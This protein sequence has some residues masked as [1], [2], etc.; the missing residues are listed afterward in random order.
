MVEREIKDMELRHQNEKANLSIEIRRLNELLTIKQKDNDELKNELEKGKENWIQARE[1]VVHAKGKGAIQ[2]YW[3]LTRRQ[4][5]SV[6]ADERPKFIQSNLHDSNSSDMESVGSGNISVW[7]E[8]EHLD[9]SAIGSFELPT[10]MRGKKS[11]R[12][13]DWQVDLLLRLIKQILAGR[14]PSI[15]LISSPSTV[16]EPSCTVYEEVSESIE[17]PKFDPEAARKRA[18]LSTVDV[19]EVVI[20]ELRDFVSTI[21]SRYRYV[22]KNYCV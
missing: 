20:A 13:I 12:L 9:E 22:S 18:R 11:D 4:T 7:D 3:V 14:D 6:I 2:T 15:A 16:I 5:P 17:I 21:L 8:E 1:D 19:P 10:M